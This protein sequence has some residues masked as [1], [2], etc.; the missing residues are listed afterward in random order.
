MLGTILA[1]KQQ[2]VAALLSRTTRADLF[3][4]CADMPPPRGFREALRHPGHQVHLIAEVKK[5]SPSKGVIR[6]D[7]DPVQIARAYEAGGASCLS[8]LTD[9]TYFQGRLDYLSAIRHAV[10][11]PL[12]R[13]DFLIDPA[14]VYEA[15]IAGADAVLLIVAALS[16]P[17][18]LAEMQ[19]VA[20]SVG[21]DVLVEVHDAHELAIATAAGATLIGVNNRNLHSFEVRLETAE[22]LIPAFPAG[23][24]AVA[25]SGIF[26]AGDTRRMA[27]AGAQAILVGESLMREDDVAAATRRLLATN[28]DFEARHEPNGG[29]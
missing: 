25:E 5:A 2:E 18:R 11:L 16:S 19:K 1:T 4:G 29:R 13:K 6:D 24:I 15:R 9:E 10:T 28:A 3:A 26:T 22:E 20:E 12:L 27:R 23:S 21:L 14:Q 8:I 17:A 7:F